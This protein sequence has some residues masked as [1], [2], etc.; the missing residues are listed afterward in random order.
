[1]KPGLIQITIKM[2]DMTTVVEKNEI[3]CDAQITSSTQPDMDTVLIYLARVALKMSTMTPDE[4][5]A[6]VQGI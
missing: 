5:L 3:E 6:W 4:Q 2:G 1:M